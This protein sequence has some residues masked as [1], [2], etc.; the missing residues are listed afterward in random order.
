MNNF[1]KMVESS[2]KDIRGQR[3][4]ILSETVKDAG[5]EILREARKKVRDIEVRILG[6][7]DIHKDSELS[8]KI[9]KADRIIT[10]TEGINIINYGIRPIYKNKTIKEANFHLATYNL[11]K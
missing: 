9:V 11:I 5:E 4:K 3:A 2:N 7:S 8:L 6:L 1:E 10:K